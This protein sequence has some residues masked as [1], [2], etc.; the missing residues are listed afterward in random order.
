MLPENIKLLELEKWRD[1]YAEKKV[2]ILD[3]EYKALANN[4][5]K[6]SVNRIEII[7][8]ILIK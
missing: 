5:N 1:L 7:I 2:D 8:I 3:I 4:F 6:F